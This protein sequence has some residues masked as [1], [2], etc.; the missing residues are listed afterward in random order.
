MRALSMV[1]LAGCAASAS[2]PAPA[3]S[4]EPAPTPVA[5]AAAVTSPAATTAPAS[6]APADD[7]PAADAVCEPGRVQ[8]CSPLAA[9]LTY[10]LDGFAKDPALAA[11]YY[12]IACDAGELDACLG[13]ANLYESG[14]GVVEDRAAAQRLYRRACDRGHGCMALAFHL[15]DS[16]HGKDRDEARAIFERLCAGGDATACYQRGDRAPTRRDGAPWFARACDAGD[17]RGCTDLARAYAD[18]EYP[19]VDAAGA[20][21]AL[22][23]LCDRGKARAC[24]LAGQRHVEGKGTRKDLARARA[25]QR[26]ACEAGDLDGCVRIGR[27]L[28]ME[29]GDPVAATAVLARACDAGHQDGC[30]WLARVPR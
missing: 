19:G 22:E 14:R 11:R 16:D 26:R 8:A 27:D 6:P 21:R 20:T 25:L 23:Q 13:L 10:G 30:A 3:T 1:F 5:P 24:D 12:Q 7:V 9:R 29:G 2:R 15:V 18:D 17:D 4:S 28:V